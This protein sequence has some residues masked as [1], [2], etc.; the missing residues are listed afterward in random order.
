V[1]AVAT[2]RS[3]LIAFVHVRSLIVL[4]QERSRCNRHGM[5]PGLAKR[6]AFTGQSAFLQDGCV[7]D[8]TPPA[9]FARCSWPVS[10]GPECATEHGFISEWDLSVNDV[11]GAVRLAA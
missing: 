7:S 10:A 5:A 8:Y 1:G 9:R 11:T 6:D 4:L 2:M 3:M